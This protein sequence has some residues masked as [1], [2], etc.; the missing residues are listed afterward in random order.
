MW[1]YGSENK[2]TYT[3]FTFNSQTEHEQTEHEQEQTEHEQT[4]HEPTEQ[5]EHDTEVKFTPINHPQLLKC[6]Y[7][8]M[9]NLHQSTTHSYSEIVEAH[10]NTCNCM[11]NQASKC[12]PDID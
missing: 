8:L 4:E 1:S 7:I 5:T 9:W 10:V 2:H 11:K 3:W 6:K 12:S